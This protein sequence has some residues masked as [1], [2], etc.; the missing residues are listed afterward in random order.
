MPPRRARAESR[1]RY[2]VREQ[3]Q[4]RGW[5]TS[6]LARGGDVLEENEIEAHFPQIGLAGDKP[7]FLFC[8]GGEP[9]VIVEA[10]NEPRKLSQAIA[11]ACDYADQIIRAGRFNPRIAVGTAGEEDQ[12]MLVEVRFHTRAG[13][14][15]LKSSAQALTSFRTRREVELALAAG[16]ATTTVSVPEPHEFVDAALEVSSLLRQAKVEAPLR[17]KV[18][19]ALTLA[20][21]QGEID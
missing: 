17:P 4:R 16:D 18:L 12:G 5:N 21:Y 19:G 7:D 3:A 6:H 11:E 2:L 14:R 13:W 1:T 8:L 9:A 15:P 10:K 20:M